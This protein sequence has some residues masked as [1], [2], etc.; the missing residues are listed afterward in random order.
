MFHAVGRRV[1]ARARNVSWRL[2]L[3]VAI[4]HTYEKTDEKPGRRSLF[5]STK[6][7]D[8]NHLRDRGD[9]VSL[10]RIYNA[11]LDV[12]AKKEQKLRGTLV[13]AAAP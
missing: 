11:T 4:Y 10:L 3:H 9:I 6:I 12:S 8:E 7:L 5:A 2:G 1:L 13:G